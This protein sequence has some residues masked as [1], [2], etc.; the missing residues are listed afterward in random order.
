MAKRSVSKFAEKRASEVI[1][2]AFEITIFN[3]MS[4]VTTPLKPTRR[5]FFPISHNGKG[6]KL[7]LIN[8]KLH[9]A[10]P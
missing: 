5:F 10:E 9:K 7:I 4:P 1:V 6:D 2:Y 3:T 8:P